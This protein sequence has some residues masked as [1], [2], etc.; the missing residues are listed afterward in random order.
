MNV[1]PFGEADLERV[2]AFLREEEEHTLQRPSQ[3]GPNDLREWT[4][5]A[6][7]ANDSWLFEED[8]ELRAAGWVDFTA[9]VGIGIGV[10]HPRWKGAGLGVQLLERSEAAAARARR[11]SNAAV[12]VRRRHG[13]CR[14]DGV[15]RLPRRAPLLRDGDRADGAAA[16]GRRHRRDGAGG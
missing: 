4:S 9:D 3:I 15:A 5:R 16:A 2:T 7:L 11:R 6:D 12:R 1:R 8:G 10:V 13:C 14:T